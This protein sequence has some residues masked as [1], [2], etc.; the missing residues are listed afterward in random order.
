MYW[1]Q[2]ARRNPGAVNPA[3]NRLL[4]KHMAALAP[5]S[6]TGREVTC[7]RVLWD[8]ESNHYEL[9]HNKTSGAHGIPQA[10][11]ASKMARYGADYLTN[12]ATQI[13]WGL[14]YIRGRY[15]SPCGALATWTSRSPHYY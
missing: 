2:I 9:A 11:P 1:R 12:P 4:A 13:A 3:T 7:L 10:L 14:A 15:R 8:N 5:Y 6:W